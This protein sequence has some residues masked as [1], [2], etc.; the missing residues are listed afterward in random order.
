MELGTAGRRKSLNN[1]TSVNVSGAQINLSDNVKLLGVT[2]DN[3]LNFDKHTS[4]V[5]SASYYHIRGLGRIRPFLDA[6]TS[7]SIGAVIVG[8][9]LDYANSVLN[10]PPQRNLQRLQRV[11]NTLASV[12]AGETTLSSNRLLASLHWLPIDQR[13]KFKIST[14]VYR[15]LNGTAPHYLSSLLT[16]YTPT[17]SLRSSDQNL[18]TIPN[19][20]TKIGSRGFRSSGPRL[21]NTLPVHL[22]S[23]NTYSAFRSHLKTHLFRDCGP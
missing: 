9:R 19:V 17:R 3:F 6:D 13:I 8:S 7:K 16:N 21:W 14:T 5:C 2:L 22:R 20:K 12:V 15:S 11:Q 1:L 4:N 23:E 18:L 10:A